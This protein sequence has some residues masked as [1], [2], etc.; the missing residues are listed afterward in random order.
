MNL[1][2]LVKILSPFI[3]ISFICLITLLVVKLFVTKKVFRSTL[4][5]VGIFYVSLIL[6]LCCTDSGKVGYASLYN[7]IKTTTKLA[8]NALV[9]MSANSVQIL[10][11]LV[12]TTLSIF[13]L[14][15]FIVLIK[16]IIIDVEFLEL[17]GAYRI[18]IK[19]FKLILNHQVI[20]EKIDTSNF[21][22][23]VALNC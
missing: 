22:Y 9:I 19:E 6:I 20:D 4:I 2:Y 18:T 12:N 10:Q 13:A 3:F 5:C 21:D 7:F 1:F 15:S 8:L 16:Q 17:S 11:G 14:A 23:L